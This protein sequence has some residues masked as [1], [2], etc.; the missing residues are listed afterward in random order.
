M[1]LAAR[2]VIAVV[3]IA[4]ILIG[5]VYY[6]EWAASQ[7]R[8]IGVYTSQSMIDYYKKQTWHGIPL[9]PQTYVQIYQDVKYNV[10]YYGTLAQIQLGLV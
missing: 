10:E 3:I 8:V 5:L 6:S 7:W 4:L 1:N 9:P 2:I